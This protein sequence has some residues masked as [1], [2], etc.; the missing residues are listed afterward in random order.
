MD[1]SK[2]SDMY[3]MFLGCNSLTTIPGMDTSNVTEMDGMFQL[4]RSL[5]T[6]PEMNTSRVTNM[7]SMF[8]ACYS[9]TEL[10][11]LVGLKVSLDLSSCSKLTHESLLNV[12]NKATDVTTSPATLTLGSTNLAKLSD[13]EKGI[14]TSKGW[15]LA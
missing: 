6:V 4:C 15:T 7:N 5:T 11:G 2:V 1:T 10:G 9:L 8:S 12:I 3:Y 14:A 13:A